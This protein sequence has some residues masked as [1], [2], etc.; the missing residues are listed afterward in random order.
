[1]LFSDIFNS[2]LNQ[3][4]NQF[5]IEEDF[6][7]EGAEGAE[8]A[9]G[10][11]GAEEAEGAEELCRDVIYNVSPGCFLRNSSNSQS[12]PGRVCSMSPILSI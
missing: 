3:L 10:A 2:L 8:G 9:G 12:S 4:I 5:W 11:G 1:M 6:G 7:A